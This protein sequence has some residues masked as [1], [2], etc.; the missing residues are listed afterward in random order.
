M[1]GSSN[2]HIRSVGCHDYASALDLWSTYKPWRGDQDTNVR[3]IEMTRKRHMNIRKEEN[4]IVCRLYN[5]DVV[6]W[7]KDGSLSIVPWASKLSDAFASQF[8]PA[9]LQPY[10]NCALGA[11]LS[12][13]GLLYKIDGVINLHRRRRRGNYLWT[14]TSPTEPFEKWGYDRKATKRILENSRYMEF[15]DWIIAVKRMGSVFPSCFWSHL[16]SNEQIL[17]ALADRDQWM[18]FAR[19]D[20]SSSSILAK[21]RRE[22]YIAADV[23]VTKM[24]AFDTIKPDEITSFRLAQL[25]DKSVERMRRTW[26]R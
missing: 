5:T 2:Y 19:V 6:T 26:R 16:G 15:H 25:K 10:F 21:L 7:Y 12:V 11:C 20:L 24:V 17:A 22:L 9:S 4:R 13:D 18:R 3:T 14:V 23:K 1:Y 8:L